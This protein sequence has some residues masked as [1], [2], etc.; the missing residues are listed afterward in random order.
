MEFYIIIL[1]LLIQICRN[2]IENFSIFL[3]EIISTI[4]LFIIISIIVIETLS[5]YLPQM[6]RPISTASLRMWSFIGL[7]N[8]YGYPIQLV[9]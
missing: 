4:L 6:Y 1:V 7:L 2:Y 5:F 9:K 3:L 8:L